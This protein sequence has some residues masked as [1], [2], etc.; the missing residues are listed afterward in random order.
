MRSSM[1]VKTVC[2]YYISF[3]SVISFLNEKLNINTQPQWCKSGW[4]KSKAIWIVLLWVSREVSFFWRSSPLTQYFLLV[5]CMSLNLVLRVSE[6][7]VLPTAKYTFSFF[8][9]L[10]IVSITQTKHSLWH[11][12]SGEVCL[13]YWSQWNLQVRCSAVDQAVWWKS[14]LSHRH[15]VLH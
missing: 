8:K 3:H 12:L 10:Y 7:N 13:A 4:R 9:T 15:T 1:P 5:P 2:K 14:S 6:S 11:F